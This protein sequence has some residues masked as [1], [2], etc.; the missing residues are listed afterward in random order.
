MSEANRLQASGGGG[1][2]GVVR[3]VHIIFKDNVFLFA[4]SNL[5]VLQVHLKKLN[6]VKK[7]KC[8][9]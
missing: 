6:M 2:E 4:I 7:L 9:L 1:G 8:L 5:V 3:N